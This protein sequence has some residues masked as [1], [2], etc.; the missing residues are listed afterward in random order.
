MI[1]FGPGASAVYYQDGTVPKEPRERW[2]AAFNALGL[3]TASS[4]DWPPL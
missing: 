2:L 3:P 4:K 1:C